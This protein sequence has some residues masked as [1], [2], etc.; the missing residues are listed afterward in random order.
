MI[1]V[2][3]KYILDASAWVEFFLGTE[4]GQ[5][6]KTI[7]DDKTAGVF[8][9]HSTVSEIFGWT[10]RKGKSFPRAI[11]VIQR[12]S[13]I[14]ELSLNDWVEAAERRHT[15]REEG[16]RKFDIMDALLLPMQQ[17]LGATIVSKDTDFQGLPNVLIL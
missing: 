4:K 5:E 17:H 2:T 9:A 8:T 6:V 16:R 3:G 10:L 7:L 15:L 11:S 1:S 13:K 12:R 14:M